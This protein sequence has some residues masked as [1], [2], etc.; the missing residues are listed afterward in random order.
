MESFRQKQF[1][2]RSRRVSQVV[3]VETACTL[4]ANRSAL[5]GEATVSS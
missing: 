3:P 2:S 4:G 5:G 1:G